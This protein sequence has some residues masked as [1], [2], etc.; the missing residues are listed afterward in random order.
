MAGGED[1]P[2]EV[3]EE[4]VEVN[5][6]H[7]ASSVRPIDMDAFQLPTFGFLNHSPC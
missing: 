4:R 2:G 7:F 6:F 3:V 1:E 5:E